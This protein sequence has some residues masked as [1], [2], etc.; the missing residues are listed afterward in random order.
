MRLD[1]ADAEGIHTVIGPDRASV[2]KSCSATGVPG[3]EQ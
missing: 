1:I 2:E 3:T